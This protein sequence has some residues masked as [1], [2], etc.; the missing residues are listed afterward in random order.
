MILF[1]IT[2]KHQIGWRYYGKSFILYR[3]INACGIGNSFISANLFFFYISNYYF[4]FIAI[5]YYFYSLPP[6]TRI[7]ASVNGSN[8][9]L[10][11]IIALFVNDSILR[12][13]SHFKYSFVILLWVYIGGN[14]L[15]QQQNLVRQFIAVAISLYGF[16]S[17]MNNNNKKFIILVSL[18]CYYKYYIFTNSYFITK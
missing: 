16:T 8:F 14:I 10:F 2:Y 17:L 11:F 4:C 3:C 18:F 9:I 1:K 7:K 5:S 15:I 13:I 12:F 6:D